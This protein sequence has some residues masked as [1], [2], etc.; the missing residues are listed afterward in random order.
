MVTVNNLGHIYS[1]DLD[2]KQFGL[3]FVNEYSL[4]SSKEAILKCKQHQ[5]YELLALVH[6][7]EIVVYNEQRLLSKIQRIENITDLVWIP[8]YNKLLVLRKT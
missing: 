7:S 8:G 1:L 2:L 6:P 5:D 4:F 3:S